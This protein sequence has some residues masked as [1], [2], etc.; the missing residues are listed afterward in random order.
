VLHFNL[1]NHTTF[2]DG[3]S[4]PRE[5]AE[6]AVK[7]G[8]THLGI[9]DHFRSTKLEPERAVDLER[10][11]AYIAEV[12][13]LRV[14]YQ[15]RMLILAGLELNFSLVQT[16][17]TFLS[18]YA[19]E[20]NPLNK[21][22]YLLFEYVNDAESM[23]LGLEELLKLRPIIQIPLG[24]A[25]NDLEKN[26]GGILQ[27]ESLAKILAQ[28]QVFV[29][30]CPTRRYSRPD[31]AGHVPYYRVE[32]EFNRRFYQAARKEGVLVAIGCDVHADLRDLADTADA[33][34]FLAEAGLEGNAVTGHYWG[35]RA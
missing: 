11:P 24:L 4:S 18:Q 20:K 23:G 22:D 29:E 33:A 15:G 28:S 26:F 13:S 3:S 6:A 34:R 25:H 16:D 10:L 17:F 5:L 31:G 35:T 14:E 32:G 19:P 1:H 12:R 27:P 7:S 9:S 8:L 2:S 21:L 30:L